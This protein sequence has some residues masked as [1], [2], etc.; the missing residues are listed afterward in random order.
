MSGMAIFGFDIMVLFAFILGGA[1]FSFLTV[2]L[3]G[4]LVPGMTSWIFSGL[5]KVPVVMNVWMD[6]YSV[7]R[8]IKKKPGSMVYDATKPTEF[9]D[10][11]MVDNKPMT[12]LHG[13]R[14]MFRVEA[15]AIPMTPDEI[16]EIQR[17]L[18]HVKENEEKYSL[19]SQLKDFELFGALGHDPQTVR[20]HMARHC[21]VEKEYIQNGKK[22]E[23]STDD[24][25][26]DI[27]TGVDKYVAE[28]D[29][30]KADIKFLP[31]RSV[32]V[33]LPKAVQATQLPIAS[34]ILK[35][36]RAE[37]EALYRAKYANA[38]DSMFKGIIIGGVVGLIAGAVAVKLL[39]G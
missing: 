31:R 11:T 20:E 25:A 30:L 32:Y 5:M 8:T 7:Y 33:D 26:S 21:Q 12:L 22:I 14:V 29:M 3:A 38:G 35:R 17:I 28:I 37:I 9:I 19:L 1:M 10:R 15:S 24:I 27:A 18:D 39:A 34:Q 6:G 23:R 13:K 36:Y 4:G 2:V 16:G